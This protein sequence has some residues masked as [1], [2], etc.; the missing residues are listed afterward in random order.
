MRTTSVSVSSRRSPAAC[1]RRW[2]SSAAT[3]P[4][5]RSYS[6]ARTAMR[7]AT[8]ATGWS[9]MCSST[10]SQASHS[11]AVSTPVSRPRPW[12]ASTSDSPGDAVER[13][14][15]RI[16]RGRDQVGA[17]TRRH[18]RVQEPRPGGTLDEEADGQAGLLADALDELLGEVRQERV[19]RIVEDDA[20]RSERGQ[21]LRALDE[22]V[23][24]ALAAGAVDEADVELLARGEDRLARLEQ[25]RHVVERVVQPED[26][27]A[28]VGRAGDEAAHDV[29]GDR[30]GS[31]SGTG[32]GAPGR[33]ASSCARRSRGCAPTGSRPRAGRPSRT[34]RRP[35]PRGTQTRPCRG[36]RR[37]GAPRRSGACRPADPARAGEWW[38][39]RSGAWSCVD[40]NLSRE[41]GR[42][43]EAS[44]Q[45]EAAS[46]PVARRA[47]CSGLR[48]GRP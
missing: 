28:V 43:A 10:R 12:S 6:A 9:P 13:Q 35:R 1:A 3:R 18:D 2:T 48:A 39:R 41:P 21:L 36:S 45:S 30:V 24:L 23:D 5:G 29:G 27:D 46:P 11:G 16:D 33:A 14:R 25:V 32:R 7:G 15:Q 17:D 26:V 38:C 44:P 8:G 20:R 37:S 31:R 22:R 34:R 42:E 4:A 19:G 40:L 47:R